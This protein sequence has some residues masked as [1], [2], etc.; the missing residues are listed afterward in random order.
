MRSWFMADADAGGLSTGDVKES[1][2]E[3][4]RPSVPRYRRIDQA[5][6]RAQF[7]P[8]NDFDKSLK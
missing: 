7:R 4:H 3:R 1:R 2:S 5:S 8:L 6:G